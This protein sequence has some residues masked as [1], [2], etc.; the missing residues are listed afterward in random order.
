[1]NLSDVLAVVEDQNRGAVLE[2]L[3]PFHGTPTGIKLT[4]AGPDSLYAQRARVQMADDLAEAA[5]AEGRVSGQDREDCVISSLT[6]LIL[7]WELVDE[8]KPVSLSHVAAVKLIRVP[9]V[10]EQVDAFAG[11][12]RNFASS[13]IKGMDA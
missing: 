11:N 8:G 3:D 5:S 12:R 10:R 1:M 7:A 6:R 4:I 9:W 2:L 13:K